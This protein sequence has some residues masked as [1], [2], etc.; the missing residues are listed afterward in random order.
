VLG[1]FL[2]GAVERFVEPPPLL[3]V[4]V[5]AIVAQPLVDQRAQTAQLVGGKLQHRVEQ[6]DGHGHG[7]SVAR[8]FAPRQACPAPRRRYAARSP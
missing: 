7:A 3:V 8:T 1:L 5:V 6:L 4:E 2:R